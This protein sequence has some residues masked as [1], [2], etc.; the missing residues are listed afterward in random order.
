MV[1]INALIDTW[2]VQTGATLSYVP[3]TPQEV[4]DI[5]KKTVQFSQKQYSKSGLQL[6]NAFFSGSVKTMDDLPF[7][8][9]SNNNTYSNGTKVDPNT[10]TK[11]A[12]T[13]DCALRTEW[14]GKISS[15]FVFA[16]PARAGRFVFFSSPGL[17]SLEL[18]LRV[19]PAARSQPP[20]KQWWACKGCA[21][22]RGQLLH[23]SLR[24]CQAC[25]R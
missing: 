5:I 11:D 10:A 19:G 14:V 23:P 12:I 9:P 1:A 21:S 20:L 22:V 3:E 6:S 13:L 15:L 18:A 16:V 17:L 7:F 25:T 8:Y 24:F 2:T 4:K